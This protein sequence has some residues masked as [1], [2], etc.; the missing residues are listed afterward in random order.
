VPLLDAQVAESRQGSA[1]R[2]AVSLFS[3]SLCHFFPFSLLLCGFS[4]RDPVRR[5]KSPPAPNLYFYLLV[6]IDAFFFC[7]FPFLADVCLTPASRRGDVGQAPV[8][9]LDAQVAESR[10][11]SARRAA[12]SLFS[13]LLLCHCFIFC[14]A[15]WFPSLSVS[16]LLSDGRKG[17][18]LPPLSRSAS[19]T[20][21][22]FI[23][24]CCNNFS[25]RASTCDHRCVFCSSLSYR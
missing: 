23:C 4:F 1:R 10:Q 11:G 16:L 20:S 21:P 7:P 17:W 5:Q 3:S 9:S 6:I 19:A 25:S 18:A 13:L 24:I 2:V 14:A 22:T 8:P 15:L 12:V